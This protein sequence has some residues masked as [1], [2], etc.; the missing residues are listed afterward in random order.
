MADTDFGAYP[1][2]APTATDN[3]LALRGAGGVNFTVQQLA[4]QVLA[5]GNTGSGNVGIGIP[6]P[7]GRLDLSN[8]SRVRWQL[9]DAIVREISTNAAA[10]A[11]ASKLSDAAE[12]VFMGGGTEW[13]R[14]TSGRLGV[15]TSTP[16]SRLHSA[17]PVIDTPP[18]LSSVANA[19]LYITGAN[20]SYGASLGSRSNGNAW[21]QV[22][23]GD[24]TAAG[25]D[26]E[27]NPLGGNVIVGNI[28]YPSVD[29]GKT[30]GWT[31]GRWS[32]GYFGSNIIVTSDEREKVWLIVGEDRR[33]KDRRI[34]HAIFGELGWYQILEQ[35]ETKGEDGARWHFGTRAQRV[36]AIFAAEGLCAPLV[37]QGSSQRPDPQ[38]K[39]PPPPALL[40]FDEWPEERS[41]EPVYSSKLVDEEGKP[42]QIGTKEVVTRKAG[43]RFGLRVDQLGLLLDWSLHERL[44]RLEA[45]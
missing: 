22:G 24:G 18:S 28:I 34:A 9:T 3:L 8:V 27:L 12:H 42:L 16:Y 43:N 4:T 1:D 31:G 19:S 15:G 17:G 39:G 45:A 29:N 30:L 21:L 36:W 14:L 10:N 37:G 23:R 40:C 20:N 38:W 13:A 7:I 26:L 41:T 44:S 25:Y 2:S 32:T 11:Y 6:N 35:V 33:A 5:L